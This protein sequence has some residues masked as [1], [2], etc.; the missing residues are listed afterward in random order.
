MAS[1]YRDGRLG[2][3]LSRTAIGLEVPLSTP[4]LCSRRNTIFR[5][6]FSNTTISMGKREH[7]NS[8][9]ITKK[10]HLLEATHGYKTGSFFS[11]QCQCWQSN[12]CFVAN[13]FAVRDSSSKYP[14]AM[15]DWNLSFWLFGRPFLLLSD[16]AN[17]QTPDLFFVSY[18][19]TGFGSGNEHQPKFCFL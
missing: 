7:T 13:S 8:Q 3:L 6:S 15:D 12:L 16:L 1:G 18:S 9:K 2:S 4:C 17:I 19:Y 11:S 10:N 5:R 14:L